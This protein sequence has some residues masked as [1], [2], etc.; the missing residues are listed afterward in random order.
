[1]TT[2]QVVRLEGSREEISCCICS[3]KEELVSVVI[4]SE[5]GPFSFCRPPAGW[6]LDLVAVAN[7]ETLATCQDCGPRVTQ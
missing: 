7:G 2:A 5:G 1:M 6:W 4:D 3:K